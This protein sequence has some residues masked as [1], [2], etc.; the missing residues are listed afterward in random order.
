MSPVSRIRLYRT[1]AIVLKRLDFGEA[2]R[3]LTLYTPDRGKVRAIAK[4][5]RRIASRKS[6]H[7]EL[8]THAGLLLAEGRNLDVVTQAETVRPFRRIREDL[9]RTTYAYHI[10]ELVD[11]FVEEGIESPATFDLLRDALA[12]LTEA[13]DPSLVARFFEVKL[14]GHLGFRPQL[15]QC[16]RC[17]GALE[18]EG[19]SFSPTAG[20]VVCPACAPRQPDAVGLTE[21]SFRV[22]RFLQTRDWAVVRRV[23]LTAATRGTLERVMHAYIR[24]LLEQDLRSAS[25]LDH[26]RGAADEL[27]LRPTTWRPPTTLGDSVPRPGSWR[28][29][30]VLGEPVD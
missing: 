7:V 20:G 4:G 5:V 27:G 11:R 17:D 14:L 8:F 23:Q 9:I 10:A 28:P 19:N 21:P 12:A 6:G 24:H 15:F 18:A 1:E 2:D 30:T 3:I 22:L 26:L 16:V 29:P 25:L 13:E